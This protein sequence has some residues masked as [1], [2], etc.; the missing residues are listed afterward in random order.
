[1]ITSKL[2]P[3]SREV[4]RT[5]LLAWGSNEQGNDR[6]QDAYV[7]DRREHQLYHALQ[8]S[9]TTAFVRCVYIVESSHLTK[10]HLGVRPKLL[11][12][13][14]RAISSIIKCG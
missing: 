7:S 10:W 8:A 5:M 4:Q 12:M 9:T 13:H 1:M 11:T 2:R 6:N 3:F 14:L